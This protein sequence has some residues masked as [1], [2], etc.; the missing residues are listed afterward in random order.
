MNVRNGG[1][2]MAVRSMGQSNVN[3]VIP[4]ET[5]IINRVYAQGSML[6]CVVSSDALRHHQRGMVIFYKIVS[7]F[8]VEAHQHH[9][10]FAARFHLVIVCCRCYMVVC[11][12]ALHDTSTLDRVV[13]ENGQRSQV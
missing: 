13:A 7:C 6:F 1:H 8:N 5:K 11:Y 4:Q 10:T 12:I 9:V 2:N 3:L